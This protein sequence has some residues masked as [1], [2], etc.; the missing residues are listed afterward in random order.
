MQLNVCLA[1]RPSSPKERMQLFQVGVNDCT[2]LQP[3]AGD[4][5]KAYGPTIDHSLH[6]LRVPIRNMCSTNAE[7]GRSTYIISIV[8]TRRAAMT[9]LDGQYM[10]SVGTLMIID[11]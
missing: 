8:P 11:T 9:S 5:T 6:E 2:R 7:T 1:L 4:Y 3:P 10:I